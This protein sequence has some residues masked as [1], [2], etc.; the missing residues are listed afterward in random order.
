MQGNQLIALLIGILLVIVSIGWLIFCWY[1]R[2][3]HMGVMISQARARVLRERQH[4]NYD[5]ER[6]YH[7]SDH[8]VSK[9]TRGGWVRPRPRYANGPRTPEYVVLRRLDGAGGL[10]YRGR[11]FRHARLSPVAESQH[12]ASQRVNE[13]RKVSQEEECPEHAQ[14]QLQQKQSKR[15]KKK[16]KQKQQKGNQGNQENP[17]NQGNQKNNQGGHV[18]QGHQNSPPKGKKNKKGKNKD[19]QEEPAPQ[20]QEDRHHENPPDNQGSWDPL[21][22]YHGQQDGQNNRYHNG[23][24]HSQSNRGN[25]DHGS[26]TKWSQCQWSGKQY[27]S[28]P[29]SDKN[30]KRGS[31]RGSQTGNSQNGYGQDRRSQGQG[32]FWDNGQQQESFS[33]GQSDRGSRARVEEGP[34]EQLPSD[35]PW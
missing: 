32:S 1:R 12:P 17:N 21:N 10:D 19:H 29:V 5:V 14:E 13:Q 4:A 23:S 27:Q 2:H 20:P 6:G 30:G 24:R 28:P 35:A 33:W 11:S 18:N 25:G 31:N 8:L 34:Q 9:Y 3:V 26:Q 16:Q 15:Q 7:D 22:D